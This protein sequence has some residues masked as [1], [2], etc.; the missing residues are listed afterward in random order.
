MPNYIIHL[1]NINNAIQKGLKVIKVITM[2]LKNENVPTICG[3]NCLLL[4]QM[5][6]TYNTKLFPLSLCN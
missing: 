3:L 4:F 6:N 2:I 1:K 5:S